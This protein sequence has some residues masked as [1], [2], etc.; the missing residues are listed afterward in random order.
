MIFDKVAQQWV[1]TNPFELVTGIRLCHLLMEQKV[2]SIIAGTVLI[3]ERDY[4]LIM[5]QTSEI[6]YI[7][8]LTE[9]SDVDFEKGSSVIFDKKLLCWEIFD[10]D[11][12]P[13]FSKCRL[14]SIRELEI[15][16]KVCS[17]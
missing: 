10:L 12:F 15:Y 5:F 8:S 17:V 11:S 16:N 7:H 14:P 1:C 9:E 2:S 6:L 13:P 4:A 3:Y